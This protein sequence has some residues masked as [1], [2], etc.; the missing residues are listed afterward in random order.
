MAKIWNDIEIT[1][2]DEAYTIR[3]TLDFINHIESDDGC[4]LSKLLVRL[5]KQDLPSVQACRLIAKT[6]NYAGVNVSAEDVFQ[7]TSGMGVDLIMVASNILLGCMPAPK[8]A[9]KPSKKKNT[10]K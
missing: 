8:D 3:P 5:T 4:S 2:Q 7:E 1:W 9:P 6:L 10:T